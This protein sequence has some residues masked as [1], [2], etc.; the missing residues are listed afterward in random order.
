MVLAIFIGT[1]LLGS[2]QVDAYADDSHFRSSKSVLHMFA[3]HDLWISVTII[4]QKV[5]IS[6]CIYTYI[7][8]L[9]WF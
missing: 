7:H 5:R 1:F 9:Q 3:D 6:L 4:S 8:I 2:F